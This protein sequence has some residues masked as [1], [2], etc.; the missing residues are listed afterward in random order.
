MPLGACGGE[1]VALGEDVLDLVLEV[2]VALGHAL[3]G[4][5]FQGVG[6]ARKEDFAK[7]ALADLGQDLELDGGG[8]GAALAEE[9]ALVGKVRVG[10]NGDFFRG[11]L[12][13]GMVVFCVSNNL[14]TENTKFW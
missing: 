6:L 14:M 7:A 12:G 9:E 11:E 3:E 5:E 4:A 1:D 8:A 2:Q 13:G 10:G